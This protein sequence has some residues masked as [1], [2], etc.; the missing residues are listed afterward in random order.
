MFTVPENVPDPE[1]TTISSQEIIVQWTE[2]AKPN[3]IIL[4][5]HIYLQYPEG[6]EEVFNST[7][8]GSYT[9]PGLSPFTQ[10][11]F[12]IFVCNTAGCAAS[13]VAMNTTFESGKTTDC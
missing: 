4:L 10:Y 6:N 8:R 3:G 9:V 13:N 2:P 11:G 12:L 5:Y 7:E 1:V